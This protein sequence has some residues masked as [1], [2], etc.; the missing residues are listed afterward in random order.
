MAHDADAHQ[1]AGP[2][3]D[4]PPAPIVTTHAT[5]SLD[6]SPADLE[7]VASILRGLGSAGEG[8]RDTVD[9]AA[10][11]VFAGGSWAG[12]TAEAYQEHRGRLSDALVDLADA[13][14]SAARALD[15][16][17]EVLRSGQAKLDA[18]LDRPGDVPALRF[19]GR[20][21][22]FPRDETEAATVREAVSA[23]TEIREWV[24]A[25]ISLRRPAFDQAGAALQAI[26]DAWQPRTV[27]HLNLNVGMGDRDDSTT[28]AR[29]D[30]MAAAIAAADTDVV[31]LQEV[32]ENNLD[33]LLAKLEA[34]TGQ[35]WQLAAYADPID[36][37]PSWD[38]DNS[39]EQGYGNA[40]LVRT[41]GA[42]DVPE[43]G[44]PRHTE[45]DQIDLSDPADTVV[46]QIFT[47]EAPEDR[48]AAVAELTIREPGDQ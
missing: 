22:F 29:L 11:L 35:E 45:R 1:P 38:P 19:L 6:A 8:T 7:G 25:E 12:D 34:Q 41:G 2:G 13:T 23:A 15:E 27:R 39:G 5:W 21:T 18:E 26:T 20:V 43:G 10:Y 14:G 4:G 47:G 37:D 44:D 31:T 24:D 9:S 33:G 3:L 30:E 17:A 48:G 40:I 16:T 46:A 32:L 36:V 42:V 28:R